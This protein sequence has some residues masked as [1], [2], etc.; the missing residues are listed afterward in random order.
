M[1]KTDWIIVILFV[2]MGLSCL[3]ISAS[4]FRGISLIQMGASIGQ[5]CLIM[6]GATVMI[7]VVYWLTQR[8]KP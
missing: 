2:V 8:K 1:K 5:T 3:F 6:M 4:S 7:G